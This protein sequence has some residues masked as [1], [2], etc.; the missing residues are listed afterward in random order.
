MSKRTIIR[1]HLREANYVKDNRV[2]ILRFPDG[3][4]VY[5]RYYNGVVYREEWRDP[6]G[7]L[8]R[9]NGLPAVLRTNGLE[10]YFEHGIK[11]RDSAFRFT[12]DCVTL[13]RT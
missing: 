1:R 4:E 10:A 6:E 2:E 12:F 3:N 8:H 11:I 7:R 5:I 9:E 13:E